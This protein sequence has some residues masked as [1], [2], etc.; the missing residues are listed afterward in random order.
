MLTKHKIKKNTGNYNYQ[1]KK[2][3]FRNLLLYSQINTFTRF[4][5]RLYHEGKGLVQV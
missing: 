3:R 1:V 4:V 5:V 2:T